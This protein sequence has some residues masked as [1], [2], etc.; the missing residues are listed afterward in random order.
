[1]NF[2]KKELEA[3]DFCIGGF[4]LWV[5]GRQF[6]DLDDY[7]D[8]NWLNVIA[9]C[10]ADS[11]EVRAAGSIIHL[12][13]LYT[14]M[15]ECKQIYDT[16]SG[17]AKLECMEPNIGL[18]IKMGNAGHCELTVAI[19]PDNLYQEHSFVFDLDQSYLLPL[20][21]SLEQILDTYPIRGVNHSSRHISRQ[22]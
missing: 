13:E 3:P 15:V 10:K 16:L 5:Y 4:E 22:K 6:P 17:E 12:T 2:S 18:K 14:L 21:K 7:W 8:G 11:S 19:T 9:R 20:F 1:M